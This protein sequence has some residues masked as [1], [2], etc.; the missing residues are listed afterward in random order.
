VFGSQANASTSGT[1][2]P[3][4]SFLSYSRFSNAQKTFFA[5]VSGTKE[6]TTYAQAILDPNWQQTMQ[7]ELT[8]LQKTN[9]WTVMPFPT[10][11]KPIGCKWVYKIKYRSDGSI[12]RYKARLVAK[13]YT[14]VEGVDY[15]ETFSPTA[16]LT[17]LRCLITIA[18]A[19]N[20]FLHQ[21]DVQNAFL[22]SSLHEEVYM[23]LPP[24]LRR[25]GEN[26]VCRLN[27]S[28]NGLKQASR[29]WFSTFSDVIQKAGYQQS[30]ADYSLFTKQR[31][32]SFTALL[33]YVDDILLT[34]NDL[35]EI[36]HLKAHM[37]KCFRIKD[38]GDLRYFLGIEFSRSKEGIYM[39]QRKY[40][41]DILQDVGLTGA[42]PASFP[43]EQNLKL[44]TD[45]GELLKEPTK[46][47]RLVG[48][49]IYLTVTR[50][51]IVYSIR[52]LSQYMQEPRKPHWDA[53]LRVLRYVKGTPGQGLFFPSKNDL[54]LKAFCDSDWG[55]C[56]ST[57]RSVSGYC[58]FL[59]SSLISW[60]SKKQTNIS[61]S[62]AEAEYR[63]M[64]NAC[65][66]LVWLQCI[67]RDLKIPCDASIPLFCDN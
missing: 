46:Y 47:R 44:S 50:P 11:H 18:A 54:T 48:K 2:Y 1:R 32:S 6:P 13:G 16:K 62:S 63:S 49:L 52:T 29:N 27:K 9:T 20:W 60:K 10:G 65:L 35:Q 8:A 12:D 37:L 36:N 42:R 19:R 64:A 66:E 55:G 58:V 38:L 30:K 39:T 5:N 41:L 23:D 31:G 56:H 4:Q 33:I 22:H 25:Q 40:A 15:R 61:R 34:G 14:Q 26:S 43:M 28:L 59:G 51:D 57:R 45:D 21:L 3:L 7:T 53:A 17:T 24:E 67:L